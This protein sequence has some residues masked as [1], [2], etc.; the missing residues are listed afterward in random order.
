MK[1]MSGSRIAR[2]AGIFSA[3][4]LALA[5]CGQSAVDDTAEAAPADGEWP[6]ELTFVSIPSE[7]QTSLVEEFDTVISLLEDELDASI[8]VETATDYAAVIEAMRSEQA[9]LANFGPFSFVTAVDSGAGAVPVAV[10][11]EDQDADPSYV[12]YGIAAADND[13]IDSLEDFEG[14]TV[15]FVDQVS[16]SGFLYPSAGL[17][18]LGIDPE[19]D[20]DA[21][22][23]GGHDAS[24]LSV[25]NDDCE[26]AFA[27]DTMIDVQ[28]IETGQL[29]ED[30]LKVVW[31]SP[32]I[33]SAPFAANENTLPEDML[34]EIRQ[35]FT[36]QVNVEWLTENGYCDSEDDCPIPSVDEGWGYVEADDSVY[37]GIREVCEITEAEACTEGQ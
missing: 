21:Q 26:A 22:N 18:E 20:V 29:A 6:S 1:Q 28:L 11:V 10:S 32:D 2:T 8:Q 27:Y 17:L 16:T 34:A 30:D 9:D 5:G 7:E 37:D 25:V 12:S 33:P 31:E 23:T 19:A 35:I 14:R 3:L 15:C 4:V 13:E 24:A 36:E